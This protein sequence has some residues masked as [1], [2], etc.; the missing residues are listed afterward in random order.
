MSGSGEDDEI[1]DVEVE[2]TQDDA[3]AFAKKPSKRA[4]AKKTS[5]TK[6]GKK[7]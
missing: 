5:S 7:I 3:T 4:A 1:S 2:D 6:K